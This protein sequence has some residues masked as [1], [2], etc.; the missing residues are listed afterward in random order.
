MRTIGN[1]AESKTKRLRAAVIPTWLNLGLLGL[2]LD[3]RLLIY[4]RLDKFE[5]V[6]V[7]AGHFST[8]PVKLDEEFSRHCAEHGYLVLLQWTWAHGC[9]WS[10]RVC[11]IAAFN[12]H[13]DVLQWAR[14]KDCPWNERTCTF[15]AKGGH[16]EV[17]KWVRENG[18]P[19]DAGTR[20]HAAR[21]G[22]LH[23]LK[24]ARESGCPL[25]ENVCSLQHSMDSYTCFSGRGSMIAPGV[26]IF[27]CTR[28]RMDI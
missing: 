20:A 18:C 27:V 12:G 13:L 14:E 24:W 7:E 23:V 16:L 19:W 4:K 28:L 21:K 6:V 17:L 5:R 22:H 15:A 11:S 26:R 10:E 25:D 9:P 3:V 1:E 8:R 2:N